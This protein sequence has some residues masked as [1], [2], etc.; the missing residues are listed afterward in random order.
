MAAR[1]RTP[2]LVLLFLA[3]SV[4][5]LRPFGDFPLN[6][7]WAYGGSVRTLLERGELRL[8][9]WVSPW[10]V[11]H[12]SWGALWSWPFGFSYVALHFSVFF[13]V[14]A[15]GIAFAATLLRLGASE[16][17]ARL[18]A[19]C[20]VA[21][22]LVLVT[23]LSFHTDVPLLGVGLCAMY[24]FVRARQDGSTGWLCV[25]GIAVAFALLN[26]QVAVGLVLGMAGALA[27]QRERSATAWLAVLAPS[28]LAAVGFLAWYEFVHGPTWAPQ[29]YMVGWT[30][31]Y[32]ADP[33]RWLPESL[34]RV[35]C[36]AVYASLFALPLVT[37]APL[38]RGR[39]AW[40][41]GALAL[42]GAL[43]FGSLPYFAN[44]LGAHGTGTL[45]AHGGGAKA[46]GLFGMA[47]FAWLA[48]AAAWIAAA[49]IAAGLRPGGAT[50]RD[51]S[52]TC[53]ASWLL[54]FGAMMPG[55]RFFDRYLMLLLPPVLTAVACFGGAAS[56]SHPR[57]AV[58]LFIVGAALSVAGSAD[59]FAW[60]E[61]KWQLGRRALAAGLAPGDIAGG[62]DW[63]A[64]FTYETN[65]TAL[66]R[67]K[68]LVEI[69]QW[70]W[71]QMNRRRTLVSFAQS[72]PPWTR[73][74]DEQPYWTP[75]SPRGTQRLYLLERDIAVRRRARG[76]APR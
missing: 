61:A 56:F 63:D 15:G 50:Q 58:A 59:Y 4:A 46:A 12:I 51:L 29:V 40:L 33:A 3:A 39:R 8:S 53:I 14:A 62:V 24:A 60:N 43:G 31:E 10:S 42:I 2:A 20:L 52:W 64:H 41:C 13:W 67:S 38:P 5:A 73:V 75:L 44:A 16:R 35:A 18:A 17:S 19:L 65:M 23:G 72:N 70:E 21:N 47:P 45:T 9:D 26:R 22:P 66:K 54:V 68:P 27:W 76:Q 74:V 57:R 36:G 30:G 49:W 37:A 55:S 71:Q 34:R 69:G 32:L 7:G 6:D 1:W 48:T 28:A 11:S 25:A